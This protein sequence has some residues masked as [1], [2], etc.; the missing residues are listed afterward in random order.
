MAYTYTAI[1]GTYGFDNLAWGTYKVWV[2][3]LGLEP[4][5]AI[6][7]IGPDNPSAN[8]INFEA[9]SME[10][11]SIESPDNISAVSLYP[12]PVNAA[13]FLKMNSERSGDYQ[14]SITDLSGKSI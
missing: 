1:D 14:I 12:N 7:T 11:T 13:L 5:Y 9:N 3:A 8:N 2:E 10:L 6:V 4:V